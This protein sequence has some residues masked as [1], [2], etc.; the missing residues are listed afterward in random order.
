VQVRKLSSIAMSLT[1]KQVHTTR[2]L[3][4]TGTGDLR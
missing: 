3:A 4:T 1:C 2:P